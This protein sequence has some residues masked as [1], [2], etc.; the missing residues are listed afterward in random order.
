MSYYFISSLTIVLQDI[1][2]PESCE[3]NNWSF[4]ITYRNFQIC[5]PDNKLIKCNHNKSFQFEVLLYNPL[6]TYSANNVIKIQLF[7]W[8]NATITTTFHTDN[9]R[10][11]GDLKMYMPKNNTSVLNTSYLIFPFKLSW[12]SG[13]YYLISF[14]RIMMNWT[15]SMN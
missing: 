8:P 7:E 15:I 11:S 3:G 4:V 5:E 14:Q 10:F 1:R 12:L 6:P 9:S 2:R 13:W